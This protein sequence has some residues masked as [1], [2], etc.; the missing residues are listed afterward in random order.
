M[1][2]IL[3]KLLLRFHSDQRRITASD[4]AI[5]LLA[6]ALVS[7]VFAFATLSAGLFDVNLSPLSN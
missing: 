5:V 1:S 3:G 4:T 7:S 2:D 6:F